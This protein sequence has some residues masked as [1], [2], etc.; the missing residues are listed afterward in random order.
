MNGVI[1]ADTWG[2]VDLVVSF[3]HAGCVAANEIDIIMDEFF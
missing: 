1:S 3:G 2:I